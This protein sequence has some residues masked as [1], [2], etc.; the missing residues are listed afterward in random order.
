MLGSVDEVLAEVDTIVIGN[1]SEEFTDLLDRMGPG[2]HV[3]D[4][5]GVAKHQQ[6]AEH[7]HGIGW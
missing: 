2:Q 1:G 3:I 5:V 4:L 6:R 7:Y